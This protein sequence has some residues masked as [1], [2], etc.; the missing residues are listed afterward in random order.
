MNNILLIK[1]EKFQ[2]IKINK[3]QKMNAKRFAIEE[4]NKIKFKKR[5][6]RIRI[7]QK[8]MLMMMIIINRFSR[9]YSRSSKMLIIY[10][11]DVILMQK[12]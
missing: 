11:M 4:K 3:Q 6:L 7:Y 8:I 10:K 9:K 12:K 5:D 1:R 2:K